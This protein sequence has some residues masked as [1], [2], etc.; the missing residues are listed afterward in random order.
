MHYFVYDTNTSSSKKFNGLVNLNIKHL[1]VW[2]N[3]RSIYFAIFDSHLNYAGLIWDQN[4][5]AIQQIIRLQ[6]SHQNSISTLK[7]S[8]KSF[9]YLKNNA[10]KF[11]DK[12]ISNSL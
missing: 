10:L 2:L 12:A 9:F 1:S 6:E 7:F 5:N 11:N 8:F 4:S 3:T